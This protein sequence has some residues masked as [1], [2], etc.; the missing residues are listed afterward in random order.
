LSS[1]A[2]TRDPGEEG[3]MA[4]NE[5]ETIIESSFLQTCDIVESKHLMEPFTLVIFGGAGDLSRRKLLPALFHLYQ[6][7]ELPENFSI[8]AFDR[9]DLNDEQYRKMIRQ[10]LREADEKGFDG[11]AWDRMS[12]RIFYLCAYFEEDHNYLRM[13][14]RMG[15]V[16][17][18]SSKGAREIIYYMAVPPEAV[19]MIVDKLKGHNLCRGIM[20]SKIIVEKPFGHDRSSAHDLNN[21][22]RNAFDEEQ[23]YRIDH[24]LAKDPVENILFFR[25]SNTI[26]EETW[27][28]RYVDNVQV[29]VAE[30]I[31]I[32]HRGLFY[33]K[34]GAVRDI[35]QNHMPQVLALM[36][37]EP[38]VAFTANFIRD[39]KLKMFQSIRPMNDGYIDKFMVR[40]QYGPGTAGE[41]KLTGY[42]EEANVSPGS[43]TPTF[44]AGKFYIDNLRW[45]GVPFYLRTGKRMPKRITE[46]CI[47]FKRLPLRLFGRTCDVLEPNILFLTIQPDE[48]ISLRFGVKYPYSSN[49]IYSALM[50]FSYNETFKG[51]SHLSYERLI[52]DVIRGDLTLFVREDTIEQMWE[53]IDP[54]NR[55]WESVAP[56]NFPNYAAGT[57]GPPGAESLMRRE[58]RSWITV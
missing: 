13:Q 7:G 46:I 37:M 6:E 36:G 30:E 40:G 17:A 24:Y 58:G 9:I 14:E 5:S 27:N 16:C 57:W 45:A 4:E 53:I 12:K 44:F 23:I 31:V 20:N 48:K 11:D 32:E 56:E 39:E 26:F 21:I 52:L 43:T 38:P 50:V 35:V 18:A 8:L 25:F 49:Q 15:G 42:R 10:A 47:Q 19:P 29:T 2:G 55:R 41:E 33:E 1:E 3:K 22:L 28:S 34:A 51:P 54:I